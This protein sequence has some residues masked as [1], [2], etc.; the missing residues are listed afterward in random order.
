MSSKQ[1]K[2]KSPKKGVSNRLSA[3]LRFPQFRHESG[4]KPR[5]LYELAGPISERA[6]EKDTD[7]VLT[8]SAEYGI[9]RQGDYFGKKIAGE[10]LSRYLKIVRNDFVYNDRTTKSY[11]LGTIKRLA[12]YESG[13]VHRSISAF[14]SKQERTQCFGTGILNPAITNKN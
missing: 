2:T 5:P 3:E 14:V 6:T 7:T 4:W 1:D 10:N 11:P 13:L 8:L 12:V 9:V